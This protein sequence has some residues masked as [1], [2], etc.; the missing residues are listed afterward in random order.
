MP[1][2][3]NLAQER[4]A[5]S[6]FVETGEVSPRAGKNKFNAVKKTVNDRVYDSTAEGRRA[7]DLQWLLK[8]GDISDLQYQVPFEVIPKQQGESAAVYVADFTY[9][10]ASGNYVVE[11]VKGHRTAEYRLKRK[12]M[13]QVHGIRILETG[14]RQKKKPRTLR[15]IKPATKS[16]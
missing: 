8:I 1:R 6:R 10:D 11:D 14:A 5:W 9:R 15:F 12:L 2:R 16:R 7:E 13:L 3:L 4:D